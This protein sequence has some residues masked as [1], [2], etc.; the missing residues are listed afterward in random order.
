MTDLTGQHNLAGK[1]VSGGDTFRSDPVKGEPLNVHSGGEAEID[2][3]MQAAEE[4]FATYGCSSRE[5]RALFLEA[6]ELEARVDA[7]TGVGMA[8]TGVPEPRLRS[9]ELPRTAN[10]LRL[11][12]THIR[13]GA[14]LDRRHDEALPD[15]QP[16]PRADLRMMQR[17][18]G[19]SASS[20]PRTSHSPL[21]R[22]AATRQRRWRPDVRLFT[23]TTL[24]T[25]AA[26]SGRAPSPLRSRRRGC[27]RASSV[28]SSRT[29]TRRDR[30]W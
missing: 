28:S 29:R 30:R 23:R 4:A 21:R 11:L 18:T 22:R 27:P 1:W 24:A 9:V 3:A 25:L 26:A 2:A 20:A 13:D 12:A 8:E 17:P 6:E 16:M 10:Q 14:Y 7:I 5:D 19:P 15:R